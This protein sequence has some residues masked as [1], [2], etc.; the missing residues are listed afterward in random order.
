MAWDFSTEPEFQEQLNWVERF[1]R[2]E[3][4]PVDLLFPGAAKSRDPRMKA[5]VDPLKQQV[6]DEGL[7]ALFLHEELGGPGFGQLKLALLNEILGQY[8]SAPVVFGTQGPDTGN[9]EILAAYGTPEQKERWLYPLMDQQI[10]SAFSMTEPQGGSDPTLFRTTAVQDG[11]RWVINGEKWFTSF[12]QDADILLVM[13]QN[14]IFIVEKDTPGIEWQFG[15]GD[16]DYVRYSDVRVPLDH[17][18]GPEGGGRTLAQRR[19]G[20][21]R[22]HHAMRTVAACKKAIDMMCERALSRESHGKVISEHQMVQQAIADSYAEYHMLRLLVLWTAWSIDNT[23]TREAR[24]QIAA[25]KYSC[26]KIQQ[27][28]VFRAIHIFGSLGVTHLTPLQQMWASVPAQFI[29]D[30][31]NE[32]HKVTVSRNVLKGY[33]A[34]AGDWP[35]EFIP[36]KRE[37]AKKKFAALLASDPELAA[38]VDR[39]EQS[40][41]ADIS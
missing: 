26:A 7:W 37:S 18:L 41:F 1:C 31:P 29:M 22:I 2:E 14:G 10:W 39:L 19:L 38:R 3:I 8:G 36:A 35:T 11:D 20:G 21:G 5:I 16:H 32:V 28:I 9:M 6:K 27:D 40:S 24:T 34:H 13:C 12:G 4:V 25:C 17:L 33:Q 15:A 30:G 23:N